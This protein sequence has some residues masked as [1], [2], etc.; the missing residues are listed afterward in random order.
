MI[1]VGSL[2]AF[3]R[4][5]SSLMYDAEWFDLLCGLQDGDQYRYVFPHHG[6]NKEKGK[7][8]NKKKGRREER[9]RRER[10]DGD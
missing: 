9:E 1:H 5:I 3:H 8:R 2:V 10:Q 7:R 4:L 6:R